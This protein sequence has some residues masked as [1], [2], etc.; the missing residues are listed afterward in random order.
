MPNA[1][2][3]QLVHALIWKAVPVIVVCGVSGILLRELLEWFGSKAGQAIQGSRASKNAGTRAEVRARASPH[4]PSCNG[5]MVKRNARRG[6][7][8]GRLG[9]LGLLS[10]PEVS[11]NATHLGEGKHRE[12]ESRPFPDWRQVGDYNQPRFRL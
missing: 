4:C 6:A 9:V 11:R 3:D 1:A 7:N 8:A 12:L 5:T 10:F 2:L